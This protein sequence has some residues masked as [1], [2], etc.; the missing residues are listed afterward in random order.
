[1]RRKLRDSAVCMEA[2]RNLPD[3]GDGSSQ[4]VNELNSPIKTA[5][6]PYDRP[7]EEPLDVDFKLLDFHTNFSTWLQHAPYFNLP[8]DDASESLTVKE[9]S[10]GRRHRFDQFHGAWRTS[11]TAGMLAIY[12]VFLI[13][14]GVFIWLCVSETGTRNGFTTVYEGSCT[15]I[16]RIST[17]C[18]LAINVFSTI[19]LGAS[20]NAMQCLVSPT[21]AEID[22]AHSKGS[23]LD[24]GIPTTKNSKFLAQ[25]RVVLWVCLCLTSIPLHLL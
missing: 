10:P 25:R 20:N 1:M 13:N 4:A 16:R 12:F 6:V 8:L 2:T 22:R 11:V 24:I 23:W 19:L 21:R 3:E 15:S 7:Q 9:V 14:L 18:H 17:W 5:Q